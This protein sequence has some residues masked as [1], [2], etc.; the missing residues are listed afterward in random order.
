MLHET[1][2][3]KTKKGVGRG[4]G[5]GRLP[6]SKVMRSPNSKKI[7]VVMPP[8]ATQAPS[9]KRLLPGA[10]VTPF[11]EESIKQNALFTTQLRQ[12]SEEKAKAKRLRA[13]EKATVAYVT[14][15]Q[16]LVRAREG[17]YST[18]L[19]MLQQTAFSSVVPALYRAPGVCEPGWYT[20]V[21]RRRAKEDEAAL[22]GHPVSL[23][24]SDCDS[25]GD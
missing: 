24:L 18:I 7:R 14:Q 19:S 20:E 1:A 16:E 13:V 25:D 17:E 5:G 9:R 4:K 12:H 23:S 6:G 21:K 2:Q 10:D 3:K 15:L 11:S 22:T 8:D